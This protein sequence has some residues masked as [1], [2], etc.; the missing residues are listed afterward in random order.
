MSKSILLF[1]LLSSIVDVFAQRE[2]LNDSIN[3]KSLKNFQGDIIDGFDLGPPPE[4]AE[5]FL[6]SNGFN[7]WFTHVDGNCRARCPVSFRGIAPL[8][9]DSTFAA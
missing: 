4:I 3:E 1:L 8:G 7:Y 6:Q 5:D 9:D 2:I